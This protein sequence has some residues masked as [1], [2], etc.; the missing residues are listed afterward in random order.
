MTERIYFPA[1]AQTTEAGTNN[2]QNDGTCVCHLSYD[3]L[4]SSLFNLPIQAVRFDERLGCKQM[5][6]DEEREG[7]CTKRNEGSDAE[8]LK[9]YNYRSIKRIIPI[10]SENLK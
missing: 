3:L 9:Y 5:G 10:L 6:K 7:N 2:T 1:C 8:R 4:L